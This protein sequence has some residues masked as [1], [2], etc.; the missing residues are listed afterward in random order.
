[1]NGQP[2][3][4]NILIKFIKNYQVAKPH[5]DVSMV[6]KIGIGIGIGFLTA[7][8]ESDESAGIGRIGSVNRVFLAEA[9][10]C[11]KK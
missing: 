10:F 1:M 4:K 9:L 3:T 5:D 11:R 8:L 7:K 6:R 2:R